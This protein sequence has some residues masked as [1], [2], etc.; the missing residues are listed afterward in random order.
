VDHY[1]VRDFVNIFSTLIHLNI[2][3]HAWGENP[4]EEG[5]E[6]IDRNLAIVFLD[7]KSLM[8]IHALT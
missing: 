1:S 4:V 2:S 7:C 6:F 3:D 5:K 8:H